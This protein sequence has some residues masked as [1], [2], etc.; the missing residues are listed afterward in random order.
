MIAVEEHDGNDEPR[1]ALDYVPGYNRYSDHIEEADDRD[2][3]LNSGRA[4]EEGNG[5]L[6]NALPGHRDQ[7]R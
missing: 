3:N 7:D 6:N 5:R 2:N 1:R 4:T